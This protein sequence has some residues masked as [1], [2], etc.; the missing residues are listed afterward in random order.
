MKIRNTVIPHFHRFLC[1]RNEQNTVKR[2]IISL[3]RITKKFRKENPNIIFTRADKGNVTVALDRG[4]YIQKMEEAFKDKNTYTQVKRNPIKNL[5]RNLNSIIKRWNK[6]HISKKTYLSLFSSY[7]NLPMA[8]GLPKIH[9]EN[10][11]FRIIISS[12]NTA[13]YPIAK[14]I[15]KIFMDSLIFDNSHVSN[16]FELMKSFSNKKLNTSEVLISLDVIALFTNIPP[17]LAMDNIT[18]RWELIEKNTT[19][20]FDEFISTIKFILS[21]TYFTFITL[22]TSKLSVHQWVHHYHPSLLT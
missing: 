4:D 3:H 15:H 18:K 1:R 7:S 13:L 10:I 5:E 19:I 12:V 9:K 21:S 14:F 6:G 17:D 2:E 16:S 20:P 8:Y 22:Y 11:P